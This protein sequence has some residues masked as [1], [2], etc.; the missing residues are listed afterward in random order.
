MSESD[1]ETIEVVTDVSEADYRRV[2]FVVRKKV[3]SLLG[4]LAFALLVLTSIFSFVAIKWGFPDATGGY[5]LFALISALILTG[6][7]FI[8]ALL[9]LRS[10]TKYL[11]EIKESITILFSDAGMQMTAET[12]SSVSSWARFE[13]IQET[14]TDMLFFPQKA[15]FFPIPKRFF[16]SEDQIERLRILLRAHVGDKAKLKS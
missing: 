13:R 2:L 14:E 6:W 12:G 11:A 15:F 10:D 4:W 9:K 8:A 5:V 1:G 16:E 3:I 7:V